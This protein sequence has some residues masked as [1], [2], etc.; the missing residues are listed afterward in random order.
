MIAVLARLA[1]I[2]ELLS[3][4]DRAVPRTIERMIAGAKFNR[5]SI[6]Y[7]RF[8]LDEVASLTARLAEAQEDTIRLL[9]LQDQ[10]H[11]DVSEF[12][13]ELPDGS[14][15]REAID[16][17]QKNATRTFH[18][19]P[20]AALADAWVEYDDLVEQWAKYTHY[21]DPLTTDHYRKQVLQKRK[22]IIALAKHLHTPSV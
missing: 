19:V 12:V 16:T 11:S 22:E 21:D 9:W 7:V 3:D 20:D 17:V 10:L 1:E 4:Y 15:L 14:T 2:E 5:L 13:L 18:A 8:L 6:G